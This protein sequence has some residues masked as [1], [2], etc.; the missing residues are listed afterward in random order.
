MTRGMVKTSMKRQSQGET[1]ARQAKTKQ[2]NNVSCHVWAMMVWN[3]EGK[4]PAVHTLVGGW[5]WVGG[6]RLAATNDAKSRKQ[7]STQSHVALETVGTK[8]RFFYL[9]CAGP[10]LKRCL[11]RCCHVAWRELIQS[12]LRAALEPATRGSNCSSP[13]WRGHLYPEDRR[14]YASATLPAAHT[15]DSSSSC[16][17]ILPQSHPPH[18]PRLCCPPC[19]RHVQSRHHRAPGQAPQAHERAQCRHIQYGSPSR[20]IVFGC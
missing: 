5:C 20:Q 18:P 14:S 19:H 7:T 8:R 15:R 2:T 1:N 9:R 11:T 4:N 6:W 17:Q 13:R 3:Q 16:S 12:L 10:V